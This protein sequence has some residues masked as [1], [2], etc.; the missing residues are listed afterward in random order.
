MAE[1]LTI[2]NKD[3]IIHLMNEIQIEIKTHNDFTLDSL[4]N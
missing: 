1:R 4:A 3:I 2:Y